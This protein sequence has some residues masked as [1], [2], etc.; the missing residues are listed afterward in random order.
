MCKYLVFEDLK[1]KKINRYIRYSINRSK[2]TLQVVNVSPVQAW[3][4]YHLFAIPVLNIL[5]SGFT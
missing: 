2:D 1:I 3:H 5:Y 4:A